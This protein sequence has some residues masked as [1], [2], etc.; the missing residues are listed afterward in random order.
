MLSCYF[1]LACIQWSNTRQTFASLFIF[2]RPLF[3][4]SHAWKVRYKKRSAWCFDTWSSS[5]HATHSVLLEPCEHTHPGKKAM[6]RNLLFWAS[7]GAPH[8][9]ASMVVQRVSK[10]VKTKQ[11]CNLVNLSDP[12]V[13]LIPRCSTYKTPLNQTSFES[14]IFSMLTCMLHVHISNEVEKH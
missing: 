1:C 3:A 4:P 2:S 13:K 12:S 6:H 5:E 7:F 14:V 9:H 8:Q 11:S 10:E